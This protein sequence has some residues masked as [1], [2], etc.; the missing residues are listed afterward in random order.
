LKPAHC[1]AVDPSG[2]AG[3]EALAL[4]DPA[5]AEVIKL[6]NE[7]KYTEAE[8]QALKILELAPHMRQALRVIFEIRK[9][10]NNAKAAEVLAGRLAALPG[11]PAVVSAANIQFAQ[12][13][14]G[15]G[16]YAE[17]LA[18]A[19]RA[20]I[21]TPRDATAQHVLGVVLTETQ[22]LGPG[23]R[24]YRRA[25]ALLG[26][27][28]GLV[29]ANLAWNLKLQGRLAEAAN[30]YEQALALR[31][32]NRRGV[33]GFAQV[34]FARGRPAR[35]IALLEEGLARWPEER[36]LRLL[37]AMAAVQAGES[38]QAL[39]LI[40]DPPETLLPAELCLRGQALARQGAP[41]EAIRHYA[42]AKKIMRERNGLA[43]DAAGMQ[44]RA[45]AYQAYFTA[46]RTLPLPRA[47]QAAGP[48]P[49][50]LLGFPRSGTSL[51]EQ[52]L[53]Q[54]PGI[55]PADDASPIADLV[56]HVTRA[57]G[58]DAAYPDLLDGL[59]VGAAQD[60]PEQVRAAY[61][62]PLR[63]RGIL[64]RQDY[65]T[66]RAPGNLWHLGLIKLLFPEAPMIHLIRHPVDVALSNFA[67]DR[68]LEG[69]ADASLVTISK[70]YA[71]QMEMLRHY[72]GQ[73]TLRYLPVR[74]EELVTAP[75]AVLA[76]NLSFIGADIAVPDEATLRANAGLAPEPTPAHFALREPVHHRGLYAHRAYSEAAPNIFAEALVHLAPWIA[77]YGYG[78]AP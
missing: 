44:A 3:T 15:Q 35:A 6:F 77:E 5:G 42:T 47:P 17:A 73:L 68:R 74:Y 8:A 43:Y 54:L 67:Q 39:A 36:T 29:L 32:E 25:L 52:L 34:E 11:A 71:L 2:F 60:L 78:D 37:R 51:L 7:R 58:D 70:H 19:G 33:G 16:R 76:R 1:C 27:A 55:A 24:H 13:L 61:L 14:V 63:A 9:A 38:A 64:H 23:E 72:R 45:A 21:A 57:V 41:I 69:G 26:R 18:P 65:F 30:L 50:F 75:R 59:I 10:Q 4:L 66:D 12:L 49:I 62:A 40:A 20:V 28:D 46:D 53:A 22:A 31:P 56:A 48:R